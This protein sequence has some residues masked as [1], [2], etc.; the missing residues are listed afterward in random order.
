MYITHCDLACGHFFG[1]H[2]TAPGGGTFT[3]FPFR[4]HLLSAVGPL[5][6]AYG[7]MAAEK[8][9]YH[10]L[11]V[12]PSPA[13]PLAPDAKQTPTLRA[14]TLS[15]CRSKTWWSTHFTALNAKSSRL[16]GAGQALGA[17]YAA[18]MLC[19][20]LGPACQCLE[21]GEVRSLGRG[22]AQGAFSYRGGEDLTSL[23][24]TPLA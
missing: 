12:T 3:D 15:V 9:G 7:R 6:Q 19:I 20:T 1:Q 21:P 18:F 10:F 2:G 11:G 16:N 13:S 17:P 4:S 8:G 14:L 5:T 22:S 23:H 24:I